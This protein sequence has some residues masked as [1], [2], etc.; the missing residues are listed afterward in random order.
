MVDTEHI[1]C[2]VY[3][4][5]TIRD[6]SRNVSEEART[7]KEYCWPLPPSCD[8]WVGRLVEQFKTSILDKFQEV[9]G[10]NPGCLLRMY[11]QDLNYS[12]AYY[13]S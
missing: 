7:S 5:V 12:D 1:L 13:L 4:C 9:I 2:K 11:P 6:S 3:I 10:Y 8:F